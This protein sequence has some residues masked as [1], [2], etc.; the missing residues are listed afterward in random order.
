[1][2]GIILFRTN[3]GPVNQDVRL[4]GIPT[5][6]VSDPAAYVVAWLHAP[7]W[8]SVARKFASWA[9]PTTFV[10]HARKDFLQSVPPQ[11]RL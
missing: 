11:D 3:S 10:H 7:A 2:Y 5:V 4:L 9:L 8:H 1:M 6:D